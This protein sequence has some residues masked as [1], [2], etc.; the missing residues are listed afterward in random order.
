MSMFDRVQNMRVIII[1]LHL[2]VVPMQ[3]KLSVLL[4][5]LMLI[6]RRTKNVKLVFLHVIELNIFAVSG[7]CAR[8]AH[9]SV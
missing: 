5:L 3:N 6:G 7:V 4:L 1:S 9:L 2:D 8:I